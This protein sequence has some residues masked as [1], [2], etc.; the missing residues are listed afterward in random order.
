MKKRITV[1]LVLAL[2][3]MTVLSACSGAQRPSLSS[4]KKVGQKTS[5]GWMTLA[6]EEDEEETVPE[7]GEDETIEAGAADEE[8]VPETDTDEN[9]G[10]EDPEE[11][12]E[13]EGTFD[14]FCD[15]VFMELLDGDTLDT[16]YFV[17]HPENYGFSEEVAWSAPDASEEA[18]EEYAEWLDGIALE[19]KGYDYE[20]LGYA[21]QITY[22]TLERF[23]ELEK[24]SVGLNLYYEPLGANV[25]IQ[26]QMPLYFAEYPLREEADIPV[27]LE[28]MRL[29]PGYY[30]DILAFE[31]AKSEA[32]LFMED[33][34]LD[35][36][37]SQ[38]E[39]FLTSEED[40]ENFLY[41]T[42]EERIDEL[43]IEGDAKEAYLQENREAVPY[44][45]DAYRLL[46]EGLEE[47]RGTGK[48]E[49][50]LCNYPDGKAYYEYMIAA[51]T[52]SSMST[53]EIVRA[54]DKLMDESM[55][56]IVELYSK[57]R[58]IFNLVSGAKFPTHDPNVIMKELIEKA[59]EDFPDLSEVEYQ[60]KY[61]DESLRDYLSPACYFTPPVDDST[62]NHIF[63]NCDR[64][65]EP[66][67]IYTTMA[68]EGYPGHLYQ[69]NFAKEAGE[70]AL[71][72]ILDPT[73]YAEGWAEYV[74]IFS[75]KYIDSLKE[76]V[77][78]Y[79]QYNELL[80][81]G[82]SARCDLGVHCEGWDVDDVFDYVSNYYE[83][84][85][86]D[87][88]WIYDYVLGD[89]AGYLDYMVGYL[90]LTSIRDEAEERADEAGEE[91]DLKK[92][93][94]DYLSIGGTYYEILRKYLFAEG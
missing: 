43:G 89:P 13:P 69:T 15:R 53:G 90:E 27:Y 72:Q 46:V 35:E 85:E 86:E 25:G 4:M 28:L 26:A 44:V 18:E 30:E 55:N 52:G 80:S 57:N 63:I 94:E 47:F 74:Q 58:R 37:I 92:F 41:A 76:D 19:M 60:I 51:N 77:A 56:G 36:V 66:E 11:I 45:Y 70:P 59:K 38:C 21:G 8:P 49:G 20:S 64:G 67:D 22:D 14:E 48:Y 31:A 82:M 83:I 33:V 29:L 9:E 39:E 73:G 6:K 24:S 79:L 68:H 88:Q 78:A 75:Y 34:I 40:E 84:G 23:I 7:D 12:P 65:E 71:R 62:A 42:F 10:E 61:V 3:A 81:L 32:G 1:L 17:A 93:H 2:L 5:S 16:H 50:G 91:F 87:A 54:V